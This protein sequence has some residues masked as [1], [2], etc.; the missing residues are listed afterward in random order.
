MAR[1]GIDRDFLLD[2]ARLD[3]PVREKV[4]DTFAKFERAT[5]AGVHL[6]KIV[7]ARDDRL[8]TIRIDQFWRGVVL[9]PDD[10]DLFTLL[11]VLP[12]DDA[13]HWA[14]RRR[15]SVNAATG[16]IEIRDSVALDQTLPELA[17]WA[18]RAAEVRRLLAGVDDATLRR[19]GVD[20]QTLAFARALTDV[21][22]LEAAR[23]FLPDSQW[24]VL[25]GLAAGMTPEEVWADLAAATSTSGG[26]RRPAV[27]DGATAGRARFDP[28]DVT[29]AVRRSQDR[30]V[31]V[32]GPAELLSMLSHPFDLWR[33][34]LHPVQ[35]KVAFG[36]YRGPARV[37]GG[38]GTGKTVVA[39]H[40]ARHLA[41]GGEGP[42]LLTTFTRALTST[43]EASL[44]LLAE[45]VEIRDRITVLTVDQVANRIYREAHGNPPLLAGSDETLLWQQILAEH[46]LPLRDRFVADEWRQVIL[47]HGITDIAGYQAASRAGRGQALT[48]G[49]R[50]RVWTVIEAFQARLREQGV[51]TYA[52]V[53]AE[54]TRL[55]QAGAVRPDLFGAHAPR[56]PV[57]RGGRRPFR[58][59]VV[60]EAQDLSPVQ[61]RLLRAVVGPDEND[62]FLAGDAHQRI[63]GNRVTLREHG[64]VVTGRAS[65]LTINYRTT[66]EIL[67][68]SLG[69]LRDERIND[70]DGGLD[71][72]AG[73]R[74]E[75]RGRR[76][77]LVAAPTPSDELKGL[78]D[79]IRRWLDEGI[80]S[81]EIGVAARRN[82]LVDEA[83]AALGDAGIIAR[84]LSKPKLKGR[85]G[86]AP[87]RP[88]AVGSMHGMK[89]LEFR[90]LAVVGVS[91]GIVPAHGSVTPADE[92]PYAHTQ[93]LQQE[94]CALFVACT[95]A[96]EQLY[97][98][99]S[100]TPSPFLAAVR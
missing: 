17:R 18:S 65:R 100:G 1:L 46:G 29:A 22:Q 26:E 33:V 50:A 77:V 54:A 38:P 6:E 4:T 40:R 76:P 64:I 63:Y 75:L 34:F 78:V 41:V 25:Y 94:R 74:S 8:R 61:W 2:F 73:Y 11:K 68:W 21:A 87:V 35:N 10:G 81:A 44:A 71:S 56:V 97:V 55:L 62:L 72:I 53:C 9:A 59:V 82:T 60:D 99:W 51:V 92:D 5:H 69:M 43:I 23:A 90:C 91:E 85:R 37:T 42:V 16:R 66:A 32:S 57:P 98:S 58:H 93:D 79:V 45:E 70:L 47:G 31:L 86:A 49:Q 88:V 96:R 7:N 52:M 83:V 30:V 80:D 20:D 48:A 27:T 28:D 95:R 36:H 67:A 15:V 24:S 3:K 39:L 13:Y 19:L 14:Q 89:G 84:A 12:H